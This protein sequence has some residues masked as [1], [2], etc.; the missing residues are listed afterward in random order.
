[1]CIASG[2]TPDSPDRWIRQM[3]TVLRRHCHSESKLYTVVQGPRHA[4]EGVAS[5]PRIG[6][7]ALRTACPCATRSGVA[8]SMKYQSG[9]STGSQAESP[10]LV[11]RDAIEGVL[12]ASSSASEVFHSSAGAALKGDPSHVPRCLASELVLR[13]AAELH[14]R[15]RTNDLVASRCHVLACLWRA[16]RLTETAGWIP[17]SV[18]SAVPGLLL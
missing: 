5:M 18:L 10:A 17:N 1:M 3:T 14:R 11:R 6:R 9:L 15:V 12:V 2:I 4:R 16:N 8:S 7:A 13:P